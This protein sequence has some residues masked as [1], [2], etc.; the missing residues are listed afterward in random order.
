MRLQ[1]SFPYIYGS[2]NLQFLIFG[3]LDAGFDIAWLILE[4]IEQYLFEYSKLII[5]KM[6][7]IILQFRNRLIR[8]PPRKARTGAYSGV[9]KTIQYE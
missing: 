6:K 8:T 7:I 5:L 4:T 3:S 2:S 1:K 9:Q